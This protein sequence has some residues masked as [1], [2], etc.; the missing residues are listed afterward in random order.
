MK[1]LYIILLSTAITS[2]QAQNFKNSSEIDN[3]N[4]SSFSENQST[5]IFTG[6]LKVIDHI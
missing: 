4:I 5:I 2:L 1:K 3:F 6:P